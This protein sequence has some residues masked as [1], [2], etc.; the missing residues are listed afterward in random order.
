[1]LGFIIFCTVFAFIV[2]MHFYIAFAW[3]QL[4]REKNKEI[5]A[6]R[7]R[8]KEFVENR[9]SWLDTMAR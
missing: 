3:W 1:M 5:A 9:I 2:F 7:K 4:N 6:I 8:A